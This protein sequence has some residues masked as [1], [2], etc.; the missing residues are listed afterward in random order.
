MRISYLTGRKY[1]SDTAGTIVIMKL[2]TRYIAFLFM[3]ILALLAAL[4]AGLMRLGRQLPALTP[5]LA[6]GRSPLMI[7]GFLGTLITLA[8]A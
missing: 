5:S 4:R 2:Q 8:K 3:A 1:N 6:L 7:S